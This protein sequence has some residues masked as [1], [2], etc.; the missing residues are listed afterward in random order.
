MSDSL[1]ISVSIR[2]GPLAVTGNTS[3]GDQSQ[4]LTRGAEGGTVYLYFTSEVAEQ[5]ISALTPIA[6][7]V[8]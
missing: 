6:G 5:W 2:P 7:S 4:T 3:L 8:R 1:I